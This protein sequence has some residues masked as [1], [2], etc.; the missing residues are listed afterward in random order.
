[1]AEK[2]KQRYETN[3]NEGIDWIEL[4]ATIVENERSR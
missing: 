2:T 4:L 3:A 1:M